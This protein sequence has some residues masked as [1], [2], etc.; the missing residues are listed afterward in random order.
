MHKVSIRII[1]FMAVALNFVSKYAILKVQ[2]FGWG[3]D[4]N[5]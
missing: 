4:W 5:V 1:G 3:I 2:E